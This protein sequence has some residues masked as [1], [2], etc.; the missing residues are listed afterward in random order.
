MHGSIDT[1]GIMDD[2]FWPSIFPAIFA[3]A[4]YGV[5]LGG[6]FNVLLGSV[7]ACISSVLAFVLFEPVLSAEGVLP[8]LGLIGIAVAGAFLMTRVG[9][10]F[11]RW[12]TARTRD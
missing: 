7:G 4:L 8:T 6:A 5:S 1:W 10:L 2:H 9:A 12:A 3:G 11:S